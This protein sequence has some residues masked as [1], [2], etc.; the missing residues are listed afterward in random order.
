MD[1]ALRR[2]RKRMWTGFMIPITDTVA[3]SCDHGNKSLG[4]MTGGR[5]LN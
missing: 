1:V 5:Y 2:P 4:S 3:D